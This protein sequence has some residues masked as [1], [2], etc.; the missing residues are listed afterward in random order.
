MCVEKI[1]G[2]TS[3]LIHDKHHRL[4]GKLTREQKGDLLEA[5][6]CYH[7]DEELP[8]MDIKTEMVFEAM[9]IEIDADIEAYKKRCEQ[10]RQNGSKGGKAKRDNLANAT[11]RQEEIAT[12]TECYEEADDVA[13]VADRIGLDRIG[14]DRIGL[15][16]KKDSVKRK[17]TKKSNFLT[18]EEEKQM[19]TDSG[20]PTVVAVVFDEWCD[21][22][23]EMGKPLTPTGFKQ[24][25]TKVQNAIA[26]HGEEF[27]RDCIRDCMSSGYQGLFFD[28]QKAS[29]RASDG[30]SAIA[31]FVAGDDGDLPFG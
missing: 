13:N 2:K 11:K 22:R 15:D 23:R 3:F 6:F 18:V 24:T 14:L 16:K 20:I 29:Q 31:A 27:V 4:I 12:A 1:E 7:A 21:F 19:I 25:I 10:N 30:Y 26:E 5:L 17:P 9:A 28:R 8:E